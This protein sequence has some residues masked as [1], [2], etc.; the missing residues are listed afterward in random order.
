MRRRILR[1]DRDG[2]E[3]LHRALADVEHRLQPSLAHLLAQRAADLALRDALLRVELQR[4]RR[5]LARVLLEL[6]A[7]QA[8]RILRIGLPY[9]VRDQRQRPVLQL[10]VEMIAPHGAVVAVA[11]ALEARHIADRVDAFPLA[12]EPERAAPG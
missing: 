2:E 10:D 3:L 12:A 5:R 7:R 1:C 11:V 4:L 8:E 6:R 9:A